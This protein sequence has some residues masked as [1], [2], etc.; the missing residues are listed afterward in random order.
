MSRQ[1][2]IVAP[3]VL[4]HIIDSGIERNRIFTDGVDGVRDVHKYVNNF[5]KHKAVAGLALL[6]F[7]F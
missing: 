4:H 1:S 3:G 6:P 2:R 5:H 7:L